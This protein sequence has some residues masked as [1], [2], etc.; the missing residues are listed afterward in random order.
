MSDRHFTDGIGTISII[1]NAV[2][3]DFFT[4][5]TT[6]KDSNGQPKAVLDHSL[7]MTIPGF[8]QSAA[9]IREAAETISRMATAPAAPATA[10]AVAAPAVEPETAAKP[11]R[12]PFP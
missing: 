4:F 5:S 6:E 8:L 9:K 3:V 10:A 7:V 12:A 1:A 11:T 2:R